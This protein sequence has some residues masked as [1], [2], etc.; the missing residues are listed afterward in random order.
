VSESLSGWLVCDWQAD[1]FANGAY[2]FV[3]VNALP[4]QRALGA[5]VADTLFFAGEATDAEGASGTVH[6]ALATGERAAVELL[7][8]G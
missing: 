4:A 8:G 7:S 2:S 3:P 1:R 6:G 5:P